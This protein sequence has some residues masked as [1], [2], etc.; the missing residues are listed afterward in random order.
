MKDESIDRRTLIRR[1]SLTL[2]GLV[3]FAGIVTIVIQFIGSSSS[4]WRLISIPNASKWAPNVVSCSSQG[5]CIF[6]GGGFNFLLL[7][8]ASAAFLPVADGSGNESIP[9]LGRC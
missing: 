2:C 8:P 3:A 1:R 4:D 9:G 6:L 5:T 7:E